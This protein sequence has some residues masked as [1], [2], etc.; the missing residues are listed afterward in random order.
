[1]T[2]RNNSAHKK[3]HKSCQQNQAASMKRL[4]TI[5]PAQ[6]LCWLGSFSLLSSG[7]VFAQ[8]KSSID[9]IVPTTAA[10]QTAVKVRA[11]SE[12]TKFQ[13]QKLS[14]K[15]ASLINR[16]R[17]AKTTNAAKPVSK[18]QAQKKSGVSTASRSK[19]KPQVGVGTN[20]T[21][22]SRVSI[23]T[24]KSQPQTSAS[25]KNPQSTPGS[26]TAA[27]ALK[28][29]TTPVTVKSTNSATRTVI[30]Q[31]K[32]Y[33]NAYIDP[34]DYPSKVTGKYNAPSSVVL[35]ERQTGCEAVLS[36]NKKLASGY[37]HKLVRNT[38][39]VA[40][41]NS[42]NSR[43]P[44]P[45][46]MKKSQRLNLATVSSIQR[47]GKDLRKNS[48]KAGRRFSKRLSNS[49]VSARRVRSN[50]KTVL[51]PNRFIPSP[52]NFLPGQTT[53]VS[54]TPIAPAG[55][56]LPLPLTAL[57]QAPRPTTIAYNIPL[58][59]VLPQIGYRPTI[60]YSGQGMAFPLSIP[61]RISSIFGFRIHPITGT[62]RFHSGID[63][64]AAMGTPIV[65]VESGRVETANW[66][67]GYGL[68]A[69]LKHNNHQ[70]TL[71]GH[72]SEIFVRP[73]QVVEKGT[74]IGRVG[75]T[76]NSTGPHLHFEVR[77]LTESG[78]VAVDPGVELNSSLA[79]LRSGLQTAQLYQPEN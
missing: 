25:Q 15:R 8:T 63:L 70:Q 40:N 12:T 2:Q 36:R 50:T 35:K 42:N 10:S 61:A 29:A 72:M 62:R 71:Y 76:G 3:L 78:W 23:K 79:K 9:N 16:L 59:S 28:K 64:A 6:G 18:T 19:P 48:S 60:A 46:W 39:Q 34:T 54:S 44:T 51:N 73:G 31:A 67:G 55:G 58:A 56:V 43:K 7:L 52:K 68:T 21:S 30:R 66:L 24:R 14:Q 74:V 65:A 77:Q 69:I 4:A 47:S 57:K 75:S 32:D 45:S 26:P 11:T 13:P 37:C 49:K 53:T 27:Q 1:M 17:K 20:N 38:A 33:N 22:T 5:L 41:S